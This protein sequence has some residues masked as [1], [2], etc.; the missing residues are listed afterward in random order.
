MGATMMKAFVS[1][2]KL[3]DDAFATLE[4]NRAIQLA[5]MAEPVIETT[6]EPESPVADIS[7]METVEPQSMAA[8]TEPSFAALDNSTTEL[9]AE[10]LSEV[11]I[12]GSATPEPAPTLP[13]DMFADGVPYRQR[14]TPTIRHTSLP[15]LRHGQNKGLG[16]P[17]ILV[18]AGVLSHCCQL[19]IAKWTPAFTASICRIEDSILHQRNRGADN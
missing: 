17:P 12:S 13:Q 15:E 8:A 14:N 6:P 18:H 7:A 1:G 3:V 19:D 10:T 2:R 11:V 9:T 5:A 16:K 4:Q